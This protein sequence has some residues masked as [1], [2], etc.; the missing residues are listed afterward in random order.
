[1]GRES[2]DRRVAAGVRQRAGSRGDERVVRAL[3]AGEGG[4]ETTAGRGKKVR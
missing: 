1:M 3:R 4:G 2:D